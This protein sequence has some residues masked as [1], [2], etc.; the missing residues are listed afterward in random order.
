M[1]KLLV[2]RS[3]LTAFGAYIPSWYDY[4]YIHSSE[5]SVYSLKSHTS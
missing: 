4:A 1:L 2:S 3:P 5:F